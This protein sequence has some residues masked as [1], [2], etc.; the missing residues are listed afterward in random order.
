MSIPRTP[1]RSNTLENT[2]ANGANASAYG[3]ANKSDGKARPTKPTASGLASAEGSPWLHVVYISGGKDIAPAIQFV[4]QQ[5]AQHQLRHACVIAD[6][7]MGKTD[8]AR[9]QTFLRE[10]RSLFNEGRIGPDTRILVH[11]HGSKAA[12]EFKLKAT[13]VIDDLRWQELRSALR[14]PMDKIQW[15]GDVILACCEAGA[16]GEMLPRDEGNYL[17][18]AGK[19]NITNKSLGEQLP[20]LFGLMASHLQNHDRMPDTD[21]I[22][23][24]LT[25]ISGENIRRIDAGGLTRHKAAQFR[26]ATPATDD[27]EDSLLRNARDQKAAQVLHAK[28]VHGSAGSVE[29]ILSRHGDH[30]FDGHPFFGEISPLSWLAS[31]QRDIQ[32]KLDLLWSRGYRDLD[33][34]DSTALHRAVD[35]DNQ[36]LIKA[37]LQ[38]GVDIDLKDD[39][40]RT[41]LHRAAE[42]GSVTMVRF[43][44][45]HK[46][47][48]MAI[49]RWGRTPWH[50]AS[51]GLHTDVARMLMEREP[52]ESLS[53]HS[54]DADDS[55]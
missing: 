47:N 11:L 18:L 25:K 2:Q 48:V 29:K 50:Y 42:L 16:L 32:K 45:D 20:H 3:C 15:K 21:K 14:Q 54:S 37:L 38:L 28:L 39:H 53:S 31:T 35:E 10:I 52:H 19:K 43:L 17:L 27:T 33:C 23:E 1:L 8:A 5:L 51:E 49:D 30:F 36:T 9:K 7:A 44:L 12:D 24:L 13:G 40:G 34:E 4:Q 26:D 55:E 22:W 6:T 46:A 41:A